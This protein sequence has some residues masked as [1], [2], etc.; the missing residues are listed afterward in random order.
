MSFT[1]LDDFLSRA[2]DRLDPIRGEGQLPETGDL[3]FV[4]D[5]RLNT[6]RPAAVLIP[7]IPRPS[8]PTALLT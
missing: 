3:E 5:D 1:T 8:G 7:V 6:I 4:D 2:S